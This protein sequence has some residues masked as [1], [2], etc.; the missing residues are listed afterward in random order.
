[1][2]PAAASLEF[3][4]RY[5][6]DQEQGK[7]LPLDHYLK[8][9]P[10]AEEV[11][12][13]EYLGLK[14]ELSVT[15]T[16]SVDA[17]S[18]AA[19]A[20]L[21]ILP[22]A[23]RYELMKPLGAGGMGEVYLAHD[24]TL[25]RQVALKFARRKIIQERALREAL[26]REALTAAR[27]VHPN[28]PPIHDLG[29][30]GSGRFFY[31][32]RLIRGRSLRNL[33]DAR[34]DEEWSLPRLIA[35]FQQACLAIDYAHTRDVVHLDLKPANIMV[36]EFGELYVVDWGLSTHLVQT[37]LRAR[38]SKPRHDIQ[39]TPSY[40]SPE[41][42]RGVRRLTPASDVFSLGVILYEI[43]T[44]ER[45]FP[46]RNVTTVL[47]RVRQAEF[48]VGEAWDEAPS[49]LREIVEAALAKNAS[50]R[51]TAREL[52]DA[53]QDYLEGTREKSRRQEAARSSLTAAD[54]LLAER[55]RLLRE[56]QRLRKSAHEE[57]P[58]PWMPG[59][60]KRKFWQL[61]D[62][63][64]ACEADAGR[65]LEDATNL[66][67]EAYRHCDEEF[68]RNRF[69]EHLWVRFCRAEAEQDVLQQRFFQNQLEQLRLPEYEARLVGDGQLVVHC[70]PKPQRVVLRRYRE[71][72]RILRARRPRELKPG[73]VVRVDAIPMGSWQLTL[74][75]KGYRPL[76]VP[77]FI[78]RN[79]RVELQL[80]FRRGAE[81]G[82]D[83]VQIPAGRFL[84]GGDAETLG[85]VDR[86]E[87]SVPEFAIQ[88]FPVTFYEYLEFVV[89]L[90]ESSPRRAAARIPR[91]AKGG[92]PMVRPDD[93]DRGYEV[94]SPRAREGRLPVSGISW[95]DAVAYAKWRSERDGRTYRLPSDEE[96]EK[97]ARGTDGRTFPWGHR[98]DASF[99][100]GVGS[101][102]AKA[103]PE[104][105]GAYRAD[106]SPYGVRDLAGGVKEW[107]RSWFDRRHN[108]RLVRGGGW[109]QSPLGAHCA[110]RLGAPKDQT[111]TFIG[112]RLVHHFG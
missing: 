62:E 39:G 53:L 22:V 69:A 3:L 10:G 27:L 35:L 80:R 56:A 105:I 93:P 48:V 4:A 111:F 37:K 61:E 97:A 16:A 8:M 90:Q 59:R 29:I 88:K 44:G 17:P 5:L 30:D 101:T 89:A 106:E 11:V 36:G 41:Q 54:G 13:R 46:F 102:E 87:P 63:L 112:F 42:A 79:A 91:I 12:A 70:E 28:I 50:A 65:A 85:A 57:E 109:N 47:E 86:R 77:V 21:P 98:F 71:R 103:S 74:E 55:D 24:R 64:E 19:V 52:H 33:L 26:L 43:A 34:R 51:P 60:A 7:E 99:C 107:C 15:A 100:K 76:R 94:P 73:A 49:E 25:D 92:A 38:D 32:M 9:F 40:M 82:E 81:I 96:W 14:G 45:A 1:M 84:M 78:G 23:E 72:D 6:A 31:A 58:E 2:D 83:F 67:A 95:H 66:Y 18:D 110:Y 108:Q 20:S 104:P 75:R 68:V